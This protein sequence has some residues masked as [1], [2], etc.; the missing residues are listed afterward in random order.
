M[1]L[2]NKIKIKK[3]LNFTKSVVYVA[4]LAPSPSVSVVA[5]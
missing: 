4:V 2:K 5:V 3:L 1:W